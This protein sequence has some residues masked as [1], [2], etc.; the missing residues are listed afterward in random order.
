M[1][2]YSDQT[3]VAAAKDY[4]A[5]HLGLKVVARRHRVNVASLRLWA[6]AYRIHG[7]K[8]VTTRQRKLY[9]A[10]FK[11]AVLRRMRSDKLSYRQAGALFNIRNRDMIGIWQRAYEVGGVAALYPHTAIRRIA[12][13]NPVDTRSRA[14]DPE[15]EKRTRQELLDEL[16][17][18]RMENAYLKKLKALAQANQQ[19]AHDKDAK[20]CKS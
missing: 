19:P 12:M 16:Q 7:A 1:G 5:G 15:D 20:S 11:M 18:L 2:K 10:E 9:T 6:A 17:Q 4:C 3:R 13:A 14:Q 8:G